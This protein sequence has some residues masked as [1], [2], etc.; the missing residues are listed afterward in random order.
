MV[1]EVSSS[2]IVEREVV[3]A[4]DVLALV[5]ER[6]AG[7]L[8]TDKEEAWEKAIEL[9]VGTFFLVTYGFSRVA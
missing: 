5:D 1:G 7:A 6:E 8:V 9:F 4:L 3:E 2:S